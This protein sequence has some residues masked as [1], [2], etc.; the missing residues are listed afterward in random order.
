LLS[1]KTNKV[2]LF[3]VVIICSDTDRGSIAFLNESISSGWTLYSYNYSATQT[4]PTL[5]FGFKVDSIHAYYLDDVS[6]VDNNASSIELLSN[7]DFEN[8][9]IDAI[10]WI[11]SCETT[12]TSQ[13][14]TGSECFGSSGNCLMA[15]CTANS[16]S[17]FFLSQS[18]MATIGNTYTISYMLNQ[19]GNSSTGSM[20]FYLDVI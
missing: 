8:S 11:T 4:T 10:D 20:S 12:C 14:I 6:V 13:I 1:Y 9:T 18:F 19:R 5:L 16:S 2:F 3:L 17:I 15:Y 7:P